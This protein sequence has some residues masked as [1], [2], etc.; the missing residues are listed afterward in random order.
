M[1]VF[2]HNAKFGVR[3]IHYGTCEEGYPICTEEYHPICGSD[4]KTYINSCYYQ[5]A[6]LLDSTLTFVKVGECDALAVGEVVRV[7]GSYADDDDYSLVVICGSD[8]L[9]YFGED[10]FERAR[11]SDNSLT[12]QYYDICIH[13]A[14]NVDHVL[15]GSDLRVYL[16][17]NFAEAQSK[18]PGLQE[19]NFRMCRGQFVTTGPVLPPDD[20][21]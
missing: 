10:E 16:R 21:K 12:V 3:I 20:R 4:G 18:K 15:C 6:T 13:E 14:I 5:Y 8:D 7:S 9:T 11:E 2:E 19:V 1:C 17:S